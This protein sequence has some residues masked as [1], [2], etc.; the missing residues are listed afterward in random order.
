MNSTEPAN[1]SR[2]C[3]A[4]AVLGT[5]LILYGLVRAMQHYTRPEP[6]TQARAFE[7]RSFLKEIKA[8]DQDTLTTYGEISKTKGFYR[9]PIKRAEEIVLKEWQS[10]AAA[11]SNLV[12]RADKMAAKEANPFE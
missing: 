6:P 3:Y 11:R 10:P 8:A 1:S 7:R 12:A 2:L 9:V 5:F 4:A